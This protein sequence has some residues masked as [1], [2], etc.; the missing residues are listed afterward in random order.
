MVRPARE[1]PAL[2]RPLSQ[3]EARRQ[4]FDSYAETAMRAAGVA[5]WDATAHGAGGEHRVDDMQH[6]DGQT[7]RTL[8]LEMAAGILC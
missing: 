7:T 8:N 6:Y 2:A 5:V 4:L 3:T 1:C